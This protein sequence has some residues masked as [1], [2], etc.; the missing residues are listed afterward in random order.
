MR[1]PFDERVRL[2]R[3]AQAQGVP[4]INRWAN[5]EL[6]VSKDWR[7]RAAAAA[8]LIEDAPSVADL[9]C[10]HML[11][12]K[13]LAP[14]QVYVPVDCVSRDART[15]LCDFNREALPPMAA[16]H[17][18]ALGLLEYIYALETFLIALRKAFS[19]GVA[20]FVASQGAEHEE[21]RLATGWV[22]HHDIEEIRALFERSNFSIRRV[23]EWRPNHFL[24]RL[25]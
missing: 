14:G 10:G 18:A 5:L 6:D 1:R 7:A 25:D 19:G 21:R 17:F 3:E 12:E 11:L 9:G 16:T 13:C 22:N 20:S 4:L 23:V 2:T 8:G 15:I 24:F